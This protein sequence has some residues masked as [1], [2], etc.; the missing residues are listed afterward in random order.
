MKGDGKGKII[1]MG[2]GGGG[3]GAVFGGGELT[4]VE[5]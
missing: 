3:G 2:G 1:K 4:M 5:G